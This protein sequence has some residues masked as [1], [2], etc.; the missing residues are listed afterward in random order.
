[1]NYYYFLLLIC[2]KHSQNFQQLIQ[3]TGVYLAELKVNFITFIIIMNIVKKFY[4]LFLYYII[5]I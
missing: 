3:C 2:F 1:M 4:I 5:N